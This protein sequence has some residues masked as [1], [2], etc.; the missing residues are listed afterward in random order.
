MVTFKLTTR[1]EL[2]TD[3]KFLSNAPKIAEILE[4]DVR[5]LVTFF[6]GKETVL[7]QMDNYEAIYEKKNALT[8][9]GVDCKITPINESAEPVAAGEQKLPEPDQEKSESASTAADLELE[10]LDDESYLGRKT[11][12]SKIWEPSVGGLELDER[13]PYYDKNKK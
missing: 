1:Q 2:S 4:T 5:F 13:D 8:Q 3:P 9:L 6:S 12:T 11:K 10:I 7:F